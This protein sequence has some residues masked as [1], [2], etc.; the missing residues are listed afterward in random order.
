MCTSF[1]IVDAVVI[2]K[3]RLDFLVSISSTMWAQ[4]TSETAPIFTILSGKAK[5][6]MLYL[7]FI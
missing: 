4:W 6:Y 3:I 5:N 1:V 7:Y 2:I